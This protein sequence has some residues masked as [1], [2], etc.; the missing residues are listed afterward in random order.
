MF[1]TGYRG[2]TTL[3]KGLPYY[4]GFCKWYY[5]AKEQI[6]LWP[7]ID[8][9]TQYLSGEPIITG[10]WCGPVRVPNDTLGFDETSKRNG[11]GLYYQ[12][13]VSGFYP[14]DDPASRINL[15]NMPHYEFVV[16]GK[17]RA[18]GMHLIIGNDHNGL[19]FDADY[20]SVGNASAGSNFSFT[21]D[22]LT[23]ALILPSFA[24]ETIPPPGTSGS[25][26]GGSTGTATSGNDAEVLNYTSETTLQL[27]WTLARQNRFGTFPSFEVWYTE[28]GV[29]RLNTNA[30]ITVDALPPNTSL[31][32]IT[33]NAPGPGIVVIK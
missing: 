6:L 21:M 10:A 33:F 16:V 30:V 28:N 15:E 27:Q 32:T 13:K 11:I 23:R 26:S 7:A 24:G 25:S 18:G 22:S 19:T 12:Q 29:L 4:G 1:Q 9:A 20:T 2:Y 3:S 31:F 17:M 5:I 14:G 8:P